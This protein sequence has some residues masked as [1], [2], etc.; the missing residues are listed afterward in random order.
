MAIQN[1]YGLA[2]Y[3]LQNLFTGA[4]KPSDV[5]KDSVAYNFWCRALYQRMCSIIEFDLPEPWRRARDFFE[6]VL[7]SR[8]FMIV[9]NTQEYGKVFQ[10]ATINGFDI[11]YQPVRAI[12]ANP[13]MN[14]LSNEFEIGKDCELIKLTPD[15]CGVFDIIT[16][17]AEKLAMIDGA[18]NMAIINSKL[19]YVF[20][21]KNKASAQAIK[22]IFDKINAGEPTVVYDKQIVDNLGG[23]EPFEFID[24]ASLKNSYITTDLLNDAQTLLNSFDCE[25]GI[26]TIP[27]EKK[28]RMI[29]DEANARKN[30]ASARITLWDECLRN[31]LDQVNAKFGLNISFKFR[32]L[33]EMDPLMDIDKEGGDKWDLRIVQ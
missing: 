21:A 9:F 30:D 25:I 7:F 18:V 32:F 28:E 6:L 26:S 14:L 19:A 4:R 13:Y 10:P 24:R 20:G 15:F 22:L 17:Y 23:D 27:A 29:T 12:V 8:G 11:Y 1:T 16:Y 5:K 33:D 31:S 3:E 2:P